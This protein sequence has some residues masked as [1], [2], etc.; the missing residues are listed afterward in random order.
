MV[1]CQQM[2]A[3]III[4]I[5]TDFTARKN[6]IYVQVQALTTLFWTSQAEGC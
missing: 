6:W 3:A 5:I 2:L 1:S 4:I